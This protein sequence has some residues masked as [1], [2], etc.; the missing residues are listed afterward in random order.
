MDERLIFSL[1]GCAVW[2]SQTVS[3]EVT[4]GECMP[5]QIV[6][7]SLPSSH[8]SLK[9]LTNHL[10]LQQALVSGTAC[11]SA[12]PTYLFILVP[13]QQCYNCPLSNMFKRRRADPSRT[14]F[15]TNMITKDSF[16]CVNSQSFIVNKSRAIWFF[17]FFPLKFQS[18][19]Y[20]NKSLHSYMHTNVNT[21][22]IRCDK[23]YPFKL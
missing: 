23:H 4:E 6:E 9:Q 12:F 21:R 1:S 18:Q 19:K 17:F 22:I 3:A 10:L 13:A 15:H 16:M 20:Y 7:V 14:L 11:R 5:E 2:S 8:L